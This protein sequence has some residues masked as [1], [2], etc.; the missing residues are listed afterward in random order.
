MSDRARYAPISDYALIG[1]CHGSALVRRDGS[2]DWLCLTRF[3]SGGVFVRLLDDQRGGAFRIS[4]R[5]LIE[6]RRRY[7]PDTNVLE[8]TLV[9]RTGEARLTDCFA[10]RKGGR[11]RPLR[12]LLR[13]IEG[14]RGRVEL[15]LEIT[16]RYDYGDLHPWLRW[17]QKERVWSAVGGDDGIVVSSD[18]PLAIDREGCAF[19]CTLTLGPRQR[20][21]FALTAAQP[22]A[23]QLRR[24]SAREID[25]RIGRAAR[26]WRA[27]VARAHDGLAPEVTRS[28]LVLKLLTCAPTGA[29]VAAP[30]T[31]LPERPGGSR[32]WDYRLSWIRDSTM[33]LAALFSVGHPEAASA[34]QRFIRTATAGRVEELQIAY[35]CY[36]ERRL[37]EL[38][39][40]HL[41]GWRGSRPV[42]VGNAAA[43]QTQLDVY[44]ELLQ[45]AHL[46]VGLEKHP[47]EDE[48]RFL[49][50]LVEA[51]AR[52]WPEPDR[53]LWE[54]RGEPRHFVYSKVMCWVALDCGLRIAERIGARCDRERWQSVRDQIR[55]S[56]EENGV[57]RERGCFV[58]AYGSRELDASLLRLPIV[59]FVPVDDPRM[60]ATLEAVREDLAVGPLVRR[61]RSEQA[62]DG[63]P[64]GE[65]AFLMA[66]FWLVDALAMAGRDDE[67]A[68]LYRE[69][70]ALGNDVGLYSEECDLE[71]RELLGNFPQ[72]FTHVALITAADQLRRLRS[73]HGAGRSLAERHHPA[74]PEMSS[75]LGT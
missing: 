10:M 17:H 29:I 32:N 8:T 43:H 7:L 71:T 59:G 22:W 74:W 35:G 50:D 64:A 24:V 52:R 12:Q 20:R 51:A 6:T 1:D 9:T 61:Y 72:A 70:L 63:L 34:F 25:A 2:I 57:D 11:E 58:Q 60:R 23:L 36:G 15:E 46:W 3:D 13:R 40:T 68:E 75:S 28:A 33:T 65:G 38:E 27:W 26:W 4:A 41:D 48:W 53:G 49:S 31:S 73:E 67:A 30:T 21:R 62:G 56:V 14:V 44:G 16:P 54:T 39:V 42:R 55:R 18:A 37:P 19:R 66:S 69:L 45:A 47:D 5:D